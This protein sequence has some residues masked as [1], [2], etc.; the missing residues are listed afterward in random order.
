MKEDLEFTRRTHSNQRAQ[1]E[2]KHGGVKKHG[3]TKELEA[4]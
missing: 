1:L 3:I 2:Q 4:M